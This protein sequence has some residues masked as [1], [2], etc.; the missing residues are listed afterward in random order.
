MMSFIMAGFELR[1]CSAM[2]K[3]SEKLSSLSWPGSS[4]VKMKS[5]SSTIPTTST[6]TARNALTATS[7]SKIAKNSF[8]EISRFPS[9]SIASTTFPSLSCTRL[10]AI[11]SRSTAA[12]AL[13]TSHST[14]ISMFITVSAPRSTKS[15]KMAGMTKPSSPRSPSTSPI[16]SSSVPWISNVYMLLGTELKYFSPFLVPAV[17]CVKAIAK[18]YIRIKSK[19]RV[20]KTERMAATIP[21]MRI[22]SSGMARSSL[23]ILATRD[24]RKRRTN[25]RTD[26]LPMPPPPAPPP[27]ASMKRVSTHVSNTIMRTSV[28]SKTNQ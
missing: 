24:K 28:E 20:K 18:T 25:L 16:L 2:S 14:P 6:S 13:T 10:T 11:S 1:S 21:L 17:S 12:T 9:V 23:A 7:D 5:A 27:A 8:L 3:N 26:A 22:M 15:R 4:S 19:Q